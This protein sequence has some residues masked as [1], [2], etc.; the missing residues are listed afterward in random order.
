MKNRVKIM[1]QIVVSLTVDKVWKYWTE[2]EHIKKW[3]LVSEDWYCPRSIN[4]LREG[5]RFSNLMV[6]KE[7]K[8]E[9]ENN[10]TYLE[11]LPEKLIKYELEDGRLVTV[12]FSEHGSETEIVQTFESDNTNSTE[13][14]QNGWNAIFESFK[15]YA[16]DPDH[17]V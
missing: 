6:L 3:N 11:I 4:D 14:Q 13:E 5:G 16:E 15:N 17:N 2:P 1:V 9:F 8:I 12:V 7:S 10:G